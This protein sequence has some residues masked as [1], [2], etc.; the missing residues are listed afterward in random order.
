[1]MIVVYRMKPVY[2]ATARMEVQA[3]TPALQTLNELNPSGVA[4]AAFLQTQVDLL[5]NNNLAWQTMQELGLA[6][7]SGELEAGGEGAGRSPLA[8]PSSLIRAFKKH[9]HVEPLSESRLVEF[10]FESVA[11]HLAARVANALVRNCGREFP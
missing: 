3:E 9:L 6:G 1:V 4:D 8:T 7:G 11:S 5:Q 2:R 10:S